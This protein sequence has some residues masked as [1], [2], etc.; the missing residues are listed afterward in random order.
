LTDDFDVSLRRRLESLAAA[1]PVTHSGAVTAVVRQPVRA[2]STSRLALAGLV[3][4][5]AVVVIGAVLASVMKVDPSPGS[6]PAGP[7]D[8][9]NGPIAATTRSGDFELTIRSAKSRYAVDEPIDITA[10][11]VYL[12]AGSVQ[13]AHGQGAGSTAVGFGVEEPVL[14]DLHLSPVVAESC[15]RST[16]DGGI[17][18]E[19]PFAKAGSWSGDDPRSDE[20]RAWFQDPVL[21]LPLGVWHMYAVAGFSID[22]CSPDPIEMRVDLTI[23]V[24]EQ[25]PLESPETLPSDATGINLLTAPEPATGCYQQYNEGILVRD[26]VSG[27]GIFTPREATGVVWPFGYMARDDGGVAL[28][29]GPNGQVVA[30][31]GRLV[32]FSG[33]GPGEDGLI[34][35]CGEVRVVEADS[36]DDPGVDAVQAVDD[37]GTFRLKLRSSTS[38]YEAGEPLDI[39]ATLAYVGGDGASQDFSGGIYLTGAQTD[40]PHSFAPGGV[41]PAICIPR[42]IGD[43]PDELVLGEWQKV[44]SLPPGTWRISAS[45]SGGLPACTQDSEGHGLR[46]SIE[47]TVVPAADAPEPILLLTAADVDAISTDTFC[48]RDRLDRILRGDLALDPTSG[49]GLATEAGV[50]PMR[51]PPGFTAEVLPDGAI[52]YGEAGQIV[53]REGDGISFPGGHAADGVFTV[54][55]QFH[56]G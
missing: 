2:R 12:G 26:P 13:I 10:S 34:H 55:G 28:L 20:Y 30:R 38:V 23:E 49:L 48:G 27:L 29:V 8:A 9:A 54:C 43:L 52:L 25:A 31:E 51:W 44:R 16:L 5:L 50:Q 21:R 22:T 4:V 56:F 41:Q 42:P 14:G 45:F 32:A 35:A 33:P 3:P 24:V 17:P 37:D 46:A 39:R 6:S 11:L 15:E 1:V 40:G 18:L 19:V 7:T 36:T 47:I 53:A